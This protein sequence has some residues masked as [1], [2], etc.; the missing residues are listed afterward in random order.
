MIAVLQTVN[1]LSGKKSF[2]KWPLGISDNPKICDC[3]DDCLAVGEAY[4][5][6][7]DTLLLRRG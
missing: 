6:Y 7:N 4:N 5:T 1:N 3:L 2:D